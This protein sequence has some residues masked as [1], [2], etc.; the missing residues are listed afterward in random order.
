MPNKL[1]KTGHE[2]S[3]LFPNRNGSTEFNFKPIYYE[4]LPSFQIDYL[5]GFSGVF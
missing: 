3:C 2:Q 1:P 5:G 4:E